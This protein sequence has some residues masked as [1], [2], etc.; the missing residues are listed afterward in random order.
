[1]NSKGFNLGNLT[2]QFKV[3][4]SGHRSGVYQEDAI[5]GIALGLCFLSQTDF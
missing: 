2:D 3:Y 5:T 1:L 4:F